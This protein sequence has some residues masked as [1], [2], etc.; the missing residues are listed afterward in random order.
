MRLGLCIAIPFLLVIATPSF[1]RSDDLL[2][3]QL[4]DRWS[5]EGSS[6]GSAELKTFLDEVHQCP[7]LERVARNEMRRRAH[8]S[9]PLVTRPRRAPLIHG[10]WG[11]TDVDLSID[12][13]STII[14]KTDLAHSYSRIRAAAIGSPIAE[15]L[16][17]IAY[18]EGIAVPKNENTALIWIS[19]AANAGFSR[20]QVAY[21]SML[22][23]GQGVPA[24][25]AEA[26]NWYRKAADQGLAVAEYALGQRYDSGLDVSVDPAAAASW[27]LKAAMQGEHLAEVALG[28]LYASGVGVRQD[29][30]KAFE[31]FNKAAAQ[32][33]PGAWVGI[34]D[35]YASGG[36][37]P[38]DSEEALRWYLRAAQKGD[39]MGQQRVGNAYENGF[40]VVRDLS[41]AL[42]WY[43]RSAIQ[44]EPTSQMALGRLYSTGDDDSGVSYNP[45]EA[46]AWYHRAAEQ[47]AV[48][49]VL[50]LAQLCPRASAASF[51]EGCYHWYKA[52]AE[53]GDA[54]GLYAM[55]WVYEYGTSPNDKAEQSVPNYALALNFY[56]LAAAAGNTRAMQHLG[57]M[58]YDGVHVAQDRAVGLKWLAKARTNIVDEGMFGHDNCSWMDLNRGYFDW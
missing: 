51:P 15:Y 17:G 28:K 52:V 27:Y 26:V 34:G 56:S 54:H 25:S 35:L 9:Q 33:A 11:L 8:V 20:A 38:Q 41:Q 30:E 12:D 5:A 37:R 7:T 44:D 40:G 16:V 42:A 58:Y 55:G 10:Q 23:Y 19:A 39:A 24:N 48:G 57:C 43:H 36:G 21:G 14:A 47:D 2:C 53:L 3:A 22:E 13:T 18:R 31:W 29:Y 1:S 4:A 6:M 49:A 46:S 45:S 50:A 32:D